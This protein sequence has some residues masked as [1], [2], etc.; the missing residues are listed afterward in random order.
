MK[1]SYVTDNVDA[2]TGGGIGLFVD[3]TRVVV[4]GQVVDADGFESD[5]GAWA[6]E[7]PPP[8]GVPANQGDF[9]IS[10]ALVDLAAAVATDD[11]VLLGFGLEALTTPTE[12]AAVLGAALDH[13]ESSAT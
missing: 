4:G 5:G 1:V 9:A 2:G 3:D 6:V 12:R 13:L 7:G 8:G 11:T 10:T